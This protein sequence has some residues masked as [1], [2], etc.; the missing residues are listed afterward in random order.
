MKQNRDRILL[1]FF[2]LS[3]LLHILFIQLTHIRLPDFASEEAALDVTLLNKKI[4]DIEPPLKQEK[5]DEADFLGLY[6]SKVKEETIA[7]TRSQPSRSKGEQTVAAKQDSSGP[8]YFRYKKST[9]S[10]G[11]SGWQIEDNLPED[12]YPNYRI[13]P[14][15]YLNV[16]RYPQISYFVQLKKVFKV[17]FNPIPSLRQSN[18]MRQITRGNVAAVLGVVVDQRGELK[19]LIVINSSGLDLYDQ[20]AIRTVRDS[21]PFSAP[22]PELLDP[23]GL[24]RMSW[25]FTV[26]L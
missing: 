26:Y 10:S 7:K 8:T 23:D 11:R 6:D 20:E 22:P 13:G 17:T 21:S 15:T 19:D 18:A 9:S 4:A 3:F 2:I 24:L 1:F 16:H 25:T 14:H 12:Y 5:P